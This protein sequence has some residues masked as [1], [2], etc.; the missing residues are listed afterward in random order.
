[1]VFW[2]KKVAKIKKIAN[3]GFFSFYLAEIHSFIPM[4]KIRDGA[5]DVA[6]F[7]TWRFSDCNRRDGAVHRL[8]ANVF[9]V[10]KQ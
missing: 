6:I 3:N 8:Y 5:R 1:M 10:Y 9:I 7:M 2:L 4:S